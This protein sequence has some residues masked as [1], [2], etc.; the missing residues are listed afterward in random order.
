MPSQPCRIPPGRAGCVTSQELV[1]VAV[2]PQ[3]AFGC[4][5]PDRGVREAA[6]EAYVDVLGQVRRCIWHCERVEI[7]GGEQVGE[8][9]AAVVALPVTRGPTTSSAGSAAII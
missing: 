9:R 4:G 7:P 1:Q 2:E 8:P 3:L 5:R 6:P